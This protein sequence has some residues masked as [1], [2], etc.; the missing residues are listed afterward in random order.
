MTSK[1]KIKYGL[2]NVNGNYRAIRFDDGIEKIVSGIV[3]VGGSKK[4]L[5]SKINRKEYFGY[6]D[7]GLIRGLNDG[8][9]CAHYSIGV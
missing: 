1:R 4:G 7:D 3:L 2:L 8:E 5:I 9:H 6:L